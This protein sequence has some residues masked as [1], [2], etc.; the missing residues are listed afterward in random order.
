MIK[1]YL[2]SAVRTIRRESG[3]TFINVIGLAVGLACCLL[4]LV[5]ITDE[6][7]YDRGHEKSD[8]IVRLALEMKGGDRE[9][10]GS[11][12]TFFNL[13]EMAGSGLAGVETTTRLAEDKALLI[14]GD[15]QFGT[16]RVMLAER[17]F[18]DVFSIEF[19]KGDAASAFSSPFTTVLTQEAAKKYFGDE[20]PIGKLISRNGTNDFEVTAVIKSLPQNSHLHFD[21][22]LNLESVE[23]RYSTEMLES[24]GAQWIYTYLLMVRPESAVQIESR[25]SVLMNEII[26]EDTPVEIRMAVQPL[27]AIHLYS[28]FDGELEP[29]GD[30]RYLYVFGLIALFVLAIASANFMNLAT[31]R[32][33]RR[34]REV[35][36]RKVLGAH[37]WQ[38]IRQFLTE[39]IGLSMASMVLALILAVAALPLFNSLTG[40]K[41]LTE[42]VLSIEILIA[43]SVIALIVGLASGSYPAFYLSSLRPAHVLKGG[44]LTK[45]T[46]GAIRLRHGLVVVQFSLSIAIVLGAFVVYRQLDFMQNTN[47]GFDRDQVLSVRIPAGVND[48]QVSELKA[49]FLKSPYVR[50]ASAA[51]HA[52]PDQL[53]SWRVRLSGTPSDNNELISRYEVDSDYLET[54]GLQITEGRFFSEEF[55]SDAESSIVI[56]QALARYYDLKQPL[57]SQFEIESSR[58]PSGRATVVGV[59]NDFQQG[60]MHKQ[61]Q[62][63]IISV[64][65]YSRLLLL[66]LD[67]AHLVGISGHL[68]EIWASVIPDIPLE[69]TFLDSR[70]RSL[71]QAEEQL[72]QTIR[73]FAFLAIFVACMGLFGL[74]A[75]MAERRTREVGI[76]KSFGAT[77]S[78]VTVLL[79]R[80]FVYLVLV[81]FLLAAPITWLVMRRWLNDFAY[82]IEMNPGLFIIT[83]ALA[84][85]V[86]ALT[87]AF[88]G[89]RAAQLNPVDTLRHD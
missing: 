17:S 61:I 9:W 68:E 60:S 86:A 52:P 53:N 42:H 50:M 47:P 33:A 65:R 88:Q 70:F 71:Y 36:V 2:S 82:R 84:I 80:D 51:S 40:K 4:I 34:A 75:Y 55:P 77:T 19:V 27:T 74:S 46:G 39:A 23:N 78:Q 57:G 10:R 67:A 16:E 43:L 28:N 7:S 15:Q 25:L 69:Q 21:L 64:A 3:Y 14:V 30:I 73:L 41:I 63:V 83:A 62:P 31:A 13:A 49:A 35:G 38:L 56:N 29:N 1:H 12:P 87:V 22:L 81:A 79:T 45:A 89:Y 26:P 11:V 66:K 59:V 18:F 37:R 5:Y 32:A 72:A 85:S 8:R 76:R 58:F 44:R 54:L 48:S 6:L 24:M 20:D